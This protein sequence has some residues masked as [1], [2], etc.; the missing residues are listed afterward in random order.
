MEDFQHRQ[1]RNVGQDWDFLFLG[2]E[3][4]ATSARHVLTCKLRRHDE[5][6]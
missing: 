3:A 4:G 6:H 2:D 5:T 1:W